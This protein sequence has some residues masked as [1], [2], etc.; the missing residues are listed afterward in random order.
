MTNNINP[1]VW[2][3]HAWFF[4]HAIAEAYPDDPTEDEMEQYNLFFSSLKNILPCSVCRKHF[5]SIIEENPIQLQTKKKL[6]K[7]LID[8]HNLVNEDIGQPIVD[9]DEAAFKMY[10]IA[11]T[12]SVSILHIFILIGLIFLL[13]KL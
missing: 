2:G 10:Q 13:R 1:D 4:L 9:D 11:P 3:P 8:I 5:Q 12:I 7:W 6:R